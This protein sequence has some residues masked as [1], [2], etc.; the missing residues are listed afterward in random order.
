MSDNIVNNLE[1]ALRFL[2]YKYKA[3]KLK[4]LINKIDPTFL[5]KTGG[6]FIKIKGNEYVMR[7]RKNL[8]RSFASYYPELPE[9]F[10]TEGCGFNKMEILKEIKRNVLCIEVIYDGRILIIHPKDIHSFVLKYHTFKK[11]PNME[12]VVYNI[13]VNIM[14][15]FNEYMSTKKYICWK[16]KFF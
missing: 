16:E 3:V 9:M 10:K 7:F 13:P 12:D 11:L 14:N 2:I 4:P 8:F 1:E 6:Y 5:G 15:N